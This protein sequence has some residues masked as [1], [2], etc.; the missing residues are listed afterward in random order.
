MY[1]ATICMR[2]FHLFINNLKIF[3]Y[4]GFLFNLPAIQIYTHLPSININIRLNDNI[5]HQYQ[6]ININNFIYI[7]TN[8]WKS[9][10]NNIINCQHVCYENINL[11]CINWIS[12][13]K[14]SNELTEHQHQHY[15]KNYNASTDHQH[16]N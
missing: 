10:I 8:F 11:N 14:L 6:F 9:T 16:Q 1:V 5:N 7:A 15:E 4:N 13:S 3:I 2:I 12:A